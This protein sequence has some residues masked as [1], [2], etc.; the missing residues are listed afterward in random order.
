MK[1]VIKKVALPPKTGL[2]F[3][4]FEQLSFGGPKKDRSK[5]LDTKYLV[6]NKVQNWTLNNEVQSQFQ[7]CFTELF[8]FFA[9]AGFYRADGCVSYKGQVRARILECIHNEFFV[10]L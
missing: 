6:K 5:W 9:W 1:T 10:H 4:D 2:S 7:L 3:Y 8:E